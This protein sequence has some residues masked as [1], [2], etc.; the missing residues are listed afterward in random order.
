MQGQDA[1]PAWSPLVSIVEQVDIEYRHWGAYE[2]PRLPVGLWVGRGNVTGDG[3]GGLRTIT[4]VFNPA[5]APLLSLAFSLEQ[6][7]IRD[8]DNV[9]KTLH[10]ATSTLDPLAGQANTF[11]IGV[12]VVAS[13]N[14]IALLSENGSRALRG[15]FLGR[16]S[17]ELAL[18]TAGLSLIGTNLSAP[19]LR[20]SAQG[21]VWAARSQS[22][23]NGGLLRPNPGLYP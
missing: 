21:Y 2:D 6:V 1:L 17:A 19:I 20:L 15:L 10:L 11:E 3:S 22:A 9:T 16:V 18:Q 4:L 14:S 5:T 7:S 12:D 8:G 23:P 13:Q